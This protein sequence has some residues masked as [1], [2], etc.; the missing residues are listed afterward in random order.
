MEVDMKHLRALAIVGIPIALVAGLATTATG[1]DA[2]SKPQPK[3]SSGASLA[4]NTTVVTGPSVAVPAGQTGTAYA[5]CPPGLM[6][7]GGGGESALFALPLT[8]SR[9]ASNSWQI[10]ATNNKSGT[11]T[12]RAYVVCA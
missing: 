12:I 8:T 11:L 7:T 6:P 3:A 4:G 1:A 5:V 9:P 2:D 10:A